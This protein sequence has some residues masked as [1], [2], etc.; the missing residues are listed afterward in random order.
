MQLPSKV[1]ILARNLV[2]P[3]NW[4]YVRRSLQRKAPHLQWYRSQF[5]GLRGLEVGG[6]SEL[7]SADGALPIYS[8]LSGLDNCLYSGQT[9]WANAGEN[10]EFRHDSLKQPGRQFICDATAL[11][12]IRDQSFECLLASHCLEHVANP[13]RALTEWQRVLVDGGLMLLVLPHKDGT[14][15]W[16]RPT[17]TL[18]HLVQDYQNQV[19]EEDLTHLQEILE[20]HDLNRDRAAGSRDKF[21]SR[22]RDNFRCR[23]MHHHVFD[24]RTAVELLDYL[25]F[26]IT[27]V[28]TFRPCHILVTARN[29]RSRNNAAFLEPNSSYRV[30]SCF[31]SDKPAGAVPARI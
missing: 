11:E 30:N 16:R 4:S 1:R 9:I 21:E 13:I 28:S 17:T 26:E 15:D 14:F 22:C 31:P 5:T 7:F 2:G 20:L 18:D 6:P 3:K 23:A 12:P 27:R 25:G 24:T 8:C 29:S 19:G 10:G